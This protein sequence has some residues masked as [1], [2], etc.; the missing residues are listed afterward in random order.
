MQIQS[1]TGTTARI[2]IEAT[3]RYLVYCTTVWSRKVRSGEAET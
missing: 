3:M 1:G 2:D